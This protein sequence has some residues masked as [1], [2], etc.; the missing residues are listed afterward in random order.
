MPL[1]NTAIVFSPDTASKIV[2]VKQEPGYSHVRW[3]DDDL[4]TVRREI[5]NFYRKEQRFTCAYCRGEVGLIAAVNSPVEHVLPKSQYLQFMFEPKNLCVI[6]ADC[7]TYKKDREGLV[8]TPLIRQALRD[9]PL[10]SGR[11]RLFHPHLDE[12]DQHIKKVAFLYV[13][14]SRKGG[15]TIFVCHL[16]RLIEELGVSDELFEDM[17]VALERARFGGGR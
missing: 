7:N 13:A 2:A 16:N 1:I 5:R 14:L 11:Y 3:G 12:Y 4:E 15:Y 10:D 8:E 9:Y 17:S 6:C